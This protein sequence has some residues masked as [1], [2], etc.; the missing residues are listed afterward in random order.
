MTNLTLQSNESKWSVMILV[1][2]GR[3]DS[4]KKSDCFNLLI[5]TFEFH[6]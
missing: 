6:K 1:N 4:F 2:L 3:L 5:N